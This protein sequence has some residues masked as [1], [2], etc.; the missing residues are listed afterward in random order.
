MLDC[1]SII[2]ACGGGTVLFEIFLT[3]MLSGSFIFIIASF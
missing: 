1:G 2:G 3:C